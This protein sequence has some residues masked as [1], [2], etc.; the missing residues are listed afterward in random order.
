VISD[1]H[2]NLQALEAVLRALHAQ[3]IEDIL[4][5]GDL[6]GYNADS[7]ACVGLLHERRAVTIAGN[8]DLIALGQ[9]GFDFCAPNPE[10]SLRRTR[11][12]LGN[13]TRA[14]LRT[15]PRNLLSADGLALIHG[16]LDDPTHYLHTGRDVAAEAQKLRERWP[17][18]RL[19][20]F[21]HT[22]VPALYQL[23]GEQVRH[24]APLPEQRLEGDAFW[25]VNPGSVDAA[26]RGDGLAQF[27]VFDSAAGSLSLHRV[28]YDHTRAEADAVA[29]GY[30]MGRV[31]Q[32]LLATRRLLRR[33]R[34]KALRTI[35]RAVNL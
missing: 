29:A 8:H 14:L 17:A 1:V 21:G 6:V 10:F 28:P 11:R 13:G 31:Q 19:C 34:R 25:F 18:A 9:L 2:G 16:A 12:R 24:L 26:R 4:C 32:K 30:R 33:A 5:L 23:R 22:H 35:G 7:D 27:A 15:L 20:F 3:A